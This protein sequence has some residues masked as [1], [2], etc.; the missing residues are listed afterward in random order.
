MI[1]F[2]IPALSA[3][4]VSSST[5]KTA[6]LTKSENLIKKK[7]SKLVL[8]LQWSMISWISGLAPT[9]SSKVRK[10]ENFKTEKH[11]CVLRGCLTTSFL[12]GVFYFSPSPKKLCWAKVFLCCAWCKLLPLSPD[13]I[14]LYHHTLSI[15]CIIIPSSKPLRKFL[16]LQGVFPRVFPSFIVQSKT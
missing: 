4:H 14:V 6:K 2:S 15:H 1:Q 16:C 8:H 7:N 10:M 13:S 5:Q 9:A 3:F 11:F 12:P